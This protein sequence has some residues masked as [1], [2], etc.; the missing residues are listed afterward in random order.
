MTI[1]TSAS[2]H[3]HHYIFIIMSD[4]SHITFKNKNCLTSSYKFYKNFI[5]NTNDLHCEYCGCDKNIINFNLNIFCLIFLFSSMQRR[6][7]SLILHLTRRWQKWWHLLTT[8]T[9]KKK[10]TIYVE[11]ENKINV[12]K[13]DHFLASL[14]W[15]QWLCLRVWCGRTITNGILRTRSYGK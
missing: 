9:H 2:H 3:Y 4:P 13:S 12:G 7:N 5:Q 11:N 14:W 10:R 8:Y 1:S 15:H 6:C